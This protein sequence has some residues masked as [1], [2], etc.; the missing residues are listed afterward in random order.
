MF[1][2]YLKYNLKIMSMFVCLFF[3]TIQGVESTDYCVQMLGVKV[4]SH[5]KKGNNQVKY[6]Y[7]KKKKYMNEVFLLRSGPSFLTRCVLSLGAEGRHGEDAVD[8]AAGP[9]RPAAGQAAAGGRAGRPAA[10]EEELGATSAGH[11]VLSLCR[12]TVLKHCRLLSPLGR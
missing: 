10:G 2:E 5:P 9:G 6:R 12:R 11:R 8:D 3:F 4:K 1:S 7:L